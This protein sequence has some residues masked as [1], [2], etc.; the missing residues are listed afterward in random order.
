[1]PL[2]QGGKRSRDEIANRKTERISLQGMQYRML[3]FFHGDVASVVS[4]GLVKE[5]KVPPR[6]IDLAIK[7]KKQFEQRP[8]HHTYEAPA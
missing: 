2:Q 1:M 5:A 8:E 3:Y 6:D 4:H 7:R